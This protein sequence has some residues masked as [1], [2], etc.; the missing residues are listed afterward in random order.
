MI[1]GCMKRVAFSAGLNTLPL[2]ETEDEKSVKVQMHRTNMLRVCCSNN[3]QGVCNIPF[4]IP[5][6]VLYGLNNLLWENSLGS[7][8]TTCK[9]GF[10]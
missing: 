1:G 7:H 2:P 8:E 10:T 5:V 3:A 4:D 6:I 9:T